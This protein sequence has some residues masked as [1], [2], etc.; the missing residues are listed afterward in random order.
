MKFKKSEKSIK[1]KELTEKYLNKSFRNETTR[2]NVN[3]LN[4][5]GDELA[6]LYTVL[7]KLETKALVYKIENEK[8]TPNEKKVIE[9]ILDER[10]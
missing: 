7:N 5:L 1:Q 2:I 4:N 9:M 10:K 6:F 8:V 3:N